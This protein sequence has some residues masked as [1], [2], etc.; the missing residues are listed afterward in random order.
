MSRL[1][2]ALE[3]AEEYRRAG[4]S[5]AEAAGD[6]SEKLGLAPH[7]VAAVVLLAWGDTHRR[8]CGPTNRHHR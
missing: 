6:I 3:M 8:E 1:V 5:K 2:E 7:V 4:L